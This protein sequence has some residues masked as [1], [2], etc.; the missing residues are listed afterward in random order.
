MQCEIQCKRSRYGSR[1]P[2][3]ACFTPP[4]TTIQQE[5]Q[6]IGRTAVRQIVRMIQAGH[7]FGDGRE[8][9]RIQAQFLVCE[10]SV[11]SRVEKEVHQPAE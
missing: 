1:I 5:R 4:L 6:E 8:T 2:E 11:S 3:S 9:V 7:E 10:C